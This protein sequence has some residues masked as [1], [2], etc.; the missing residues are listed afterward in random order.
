MT[1]S[2]EGMDSRPTITTH[3][4]Y[5]QGE[6]EKKKEVWTQL[7][8][9]PLSHLQTPYTNW[10]ARHGEIHT[11]RQYDTCR[12]ETVFVQVNCPTAHWSRRRAT[13]CWPR[14]SSRPRWKSFR[15]LSAAPNSVLLCVPSFKSHGGDRIISATTTMVL[16]FLSFV[17]VLLIQ[18]PLSTFFF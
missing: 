13:Q 17:S 8:P 10:M 14:I 5:T 6:K 12:W 9:P 16:D 4:E 3:K 15:L 7:L 18:T 2:D 1:P 11:R